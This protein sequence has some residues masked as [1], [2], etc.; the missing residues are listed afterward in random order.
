MICLTHHF[1]TPHEVA[2]LLRVSHMTVYRMIED[3][4]LEPVLRHPYRIPQATLTAYLK[5]SLTI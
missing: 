5:N 2:S 1:Y 3:G 4:R